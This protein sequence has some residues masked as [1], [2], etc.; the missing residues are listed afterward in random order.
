LNIDKEE[1]FDTLCE[2]PFNSDRKRMSL[3]LRDQGKLYLYSKG[4]DSVMMPRLKFNADSTE[5]M[6]QQK[7][8]EDNL[9]KFASDGLRV[10]VIASKEISEEEYHK[11]SD[12]Y[13]SLRTSK[14]K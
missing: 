6:E 12:K 10:L 7:Q 14:M 2:F 5:D 13:D 11:F 3:I 1:V 8:V 4:A 9:H